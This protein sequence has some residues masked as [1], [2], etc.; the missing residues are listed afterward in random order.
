MIFSSQISYILYLT[1]YLL[2]LKSPAG[3][4]EM[5]RPLNNLILSYTYIIFPDSCFTVY[6]IDTCFGE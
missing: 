6:N 1:V 5:K 4:Y 3:A 2:Y